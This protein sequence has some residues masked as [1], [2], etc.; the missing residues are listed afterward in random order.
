MGVKVENLEKNMAKITVTVA[1]KEFD[2]AVEKAYQKNKSH[3]N[4]PGFRKGKATKK[5]I[6]K[7]YG[8]Q[9]F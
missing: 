8:S 2:E 9:V 5:V 1:A 4:V 7:A 3:Y 6:E